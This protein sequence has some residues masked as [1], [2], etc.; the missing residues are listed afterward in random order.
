MDSFLPDAPASPKDEAYYY[1]GQI[2][3]VVIINQAGEV[4]F[5]QVGQVPYEA[6]DDVLRVAFDLLPRSESD[7]L[8]QRRSF[9]EFSSELTLE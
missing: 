5:D 1:R 6:M 2:P 9:N 3:P 8:L 4:I 7:Q